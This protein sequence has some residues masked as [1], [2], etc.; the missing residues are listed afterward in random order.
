MHCIVQLPAFGAVMTPEKP[1][2]GAIRPGEPPYRS[3][4]GVEPGSTDNREGSATIR[5]AMALLV[6]V[7]RVVAVLIGVWAGF[8]AYFAMI[9]R[10]DSLDEFEMVKQFDREVGGWFALAVILFFLPN[11]IKKPVQCVLILG[12]AALVWLF[13]S[14][15]L[16]AHHEW[17]DRVRSGH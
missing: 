10:F 4:P 8:W 11:R 15:N 9:F 2:D 13:V 7:L 5:L 12:I 16:I 3:G 1:T 14:W 6:L 17:V